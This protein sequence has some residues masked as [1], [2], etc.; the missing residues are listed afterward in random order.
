MLGCFMPDAPSG[1]VATW[2]PAISIMI[3]AGSAVYSFG[4]WR[5]QLIGSKKAEAAEKLLAGCYEARDIID[6]ARS[7]V[8]FDKEGK[9]RP[10]SIGETEAQVRLFNR[11]WAPAER[12]R[13]KDEFFAK[14]A[15]AQYSSRACLGDSVTLPVNL[16]IK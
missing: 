4:S 7:P 2:L 6:A 11:Y 13:N 16:I 10:Y 9:E 15:A 5:R 3:A 1:G 8:S 12:L 14:L